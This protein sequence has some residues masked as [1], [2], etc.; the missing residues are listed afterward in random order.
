MQFVELN[1]T[2]KLE[3]GVLVFRYPGILCHG[4]EMA[5]FFKQVGRRIEFHYFASIK[6][7]YPVEEDMSVLR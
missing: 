7:H 4:V 1:Q 5:L 6:H 3:S 2:E